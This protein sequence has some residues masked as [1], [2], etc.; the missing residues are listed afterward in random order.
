MSGSIFVGRKLELELWLRD[1][2]SDA[3]QNLKP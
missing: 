3:S 2:R 1:Y